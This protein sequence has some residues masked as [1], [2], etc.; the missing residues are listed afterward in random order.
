[1][2]CKAYTRDEMSVENWR[3]SINIWEDPLVRDTESFRITTPFHQDLAQLKVVDLWIH[4]TREWDI[5][6]LEELFISR[7]IEAIANIPLN[8]H[9]K[10]WSLWPRSLTPAKGGK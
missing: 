2:E 7:D 9:Y 10:K 3:Q 6:L 5:E 1:M 4:G 8:L